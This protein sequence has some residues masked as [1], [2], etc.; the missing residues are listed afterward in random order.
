MPSEKVR[1]LR[2]NLLSSASLH[3][4]DLTERNEYIG[5]GYLRRALVLAAVPDAH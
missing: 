4:L 5:Q 1:G 3:Y 2:M